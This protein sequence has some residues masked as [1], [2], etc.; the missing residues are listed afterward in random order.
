[1]HADEVKKT[2]PVVKMDSA[3][4]DI[5]N[6]AKLARSPEELIRLKAAYLYRKPPSIEPRVSAADMAT[7]KAA[8][9]ESLAKIRAKGSV[10]EIMAVEIAEGLRETRASAR[11]PEERIQLTTEF[12]RLNA[13][14]L[15]ESTHPKAQTSLSQEVRKISAPARP[16]QDQ[17]QNQVCEVLED[18]R[19][20]AKTPQQLIQQNANFLYL[21]RDVLQQSPAPA[22]P[23]KSHLP[24]DHK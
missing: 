3:Q 8:Y 9:A 19:R 1:L 10:P 23:A 22:T 24:H 18:I 20:S 2:V 14:A 15:A 13:D 11:T 5:E 6:L 4:A 17:L 21:N 16:A 7:R 12:Y